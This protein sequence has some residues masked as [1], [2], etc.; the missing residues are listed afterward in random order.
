MVF[1][2]YLYAK[3]LQIKFQDAYQAFYRSY[4]LVLSVNHIFIFWNHLGKWSASL[5]LR[6]KL[7]HKLYLWINFTDSSWQCVLDQ[8]VACNHESQSFFVTDPHE[9]LWDSW[10]IQSTCSNILNTLQINYWMKIGILTEYPKWRWTSMSQMILTLFV[11]AL[12]LKEWRLPLES[13]QNYA[14]QFTSLYKDMAY[15]AT[16]LR[17]L[18]NSEEWLCTPLVLFQKNNWPVMKLGNIDF[19]S[20]PQVKLQNRLLYLSS[21]IDVQKEDMCGL[22]WLNN[23]SW[24][25]AFRFPLDFALLYI[26][27][28]TETIS[29]KEQAVHNK[30]TKELVN[31]TSQLAF[32]HGIDV[33]MESSIL[34]PKEVYNHCNS[35]LQMNLF[36]KLISCLDNYNQATDIKE[37]IIALQDMWFYH[38]FIEHQY[39]MISRVYNAFSLHK[40]FPDEICACIPLTTVKMW[41]TFLVAIP[42]HQ[43]K[44]AIDRMIQT[45]TENY[46]YAP[47]LLYASWKEWFIDHGV[48]TT[49]Y[50][51]KWFYSSHITPW[52]IELLTWTWKRII[53]DYDIIINHQELSDWISFDL[54]KKKMRVNGE[55][56]NYKKICSQSATIEIM[57][58][59]FNHLWEFV[60]NH[61]LPA[62]TYSKNKNEM[63]SKIILPL[64]QLI[65]KQFW[66]QLEIQ[67]SGTL[68][69]R[70]ICLKNKPSCIHL[71]QQVK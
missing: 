63:I 55:K 40:S 51:S 58:F 5:N 56:I 19:T 26:G 29:D 69:E 48:Q 47:T 6:Q 62:S 1:M 20:I 33:D 59:L 50:L 12:F 13:L 45:L 7:P 16:Y 52:T 43:S 9:Y 23:F 42:R 10:A 68:F 61:K 30:S 41:G 49:Q 4:D 67:C 38:C 31:R 57:L 64:Q 25:S 60:P 32:A 2:T 37:L 66:E 24:D 22:I 70:S 35:M 18:M 71:L 54:L 15:L 39:E 34:L 21:V 14:F 3:D 11:V 46:W 36:Q 27:E 17:Y 53:G 8:V 44:Q 28:E 65:A